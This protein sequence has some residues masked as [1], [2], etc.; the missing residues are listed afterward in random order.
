MKLCIEEH[1]LSGRTLAAYQAVL[2]AKSRSFQRMEA[3]RGSILLTWVLPL[4]AD[5]SSAHC[6][7]GDGVR[8]CAGCFTRIILSASY[9][10]PVNKSCFTDDS[11]QTCWAR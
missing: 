3:M 7:V 4:H 2:S 10:C 9:N 8:V 6:C 11:E 5:N 1:S